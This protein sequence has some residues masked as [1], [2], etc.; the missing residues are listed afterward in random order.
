MTTQ[1]SYYRVRLG[2]GHKNADKCYQ[3]EFFGVLDAGIFGDLSYDLP[4]DRNVFIEKFRSKFLERNP[5]KTKGAATRACGTNWNVSKGIKTGDIVLCPNGKGKYWIGEV[6]SDYLYEAD[7]FFPHQRKVAWFPALVAHVDMSL[8]LKRS[9]GSIKTD[10]NI[11]KYAEEIEKFIS[12]VSPSQLNASDESVEDASE[13]ALEEHLEDFLVKNW[14]STE[15]GKKYDIYEED[16]E[17]IGQQFQTDTGPI[18]ILA[19]S[20]DKKEFLVIELKKGQASDKVVGQILRY[21]DYV[22]EAE[23][24]RGEKV[25]GAII[26]FEDNKGLERA[27]SAVGNIDFYEYKVNFSL[28]KK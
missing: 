6:I 2:K 23:A 9:A 3:G 10:V 1:K 21:M 5:T 11:T 15:L 17:I 16:G 20:K 12:G 27:L 7:S 18:D 13:F 28:S 24:M 14:A 26:A 22:Q 25:R 19:I 8:G 4:E